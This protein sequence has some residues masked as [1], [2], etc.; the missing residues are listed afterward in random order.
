MLNT[1]SK[2]SLLVFTA[3]SA[4]LGAGTA[5]CAKEDPLFCT[6]DQMCD[7]GY[8]YCDVSGA[9][10]ASGFHGNTCIPEPC[11]DAGPPDYDAGIADAGVDAGSAPDAYE[12]QPAALD[13]SP[14]GR[15]FGSVVLGNQSGSATFVVTNV[16]E[17][18]SGSISVT[19][20]GAAAGDF[21][22]ETDD[23]TGT[24]SPSGTCDIDVHFAPTATSARLATLD[25]EASPGGM[26]SA[27]LDGIGLAAGDLSLSP[28]THGFGTVSV[29][30]TT[31]AV[32]L[33]VT[34][35]GGSPTGTLVTTL[36]DE[37]NFGITT[38]NC[39]DI[40]LNAGASCT[41]SVAASPTSVGAQVGSLTVEATPG[42]QTA[43][44]LTATGEVQ[45]DIVINGL[46]GGT[47]TSVPAGID[48]GSDC[49]QSY[50]SATSVTLTATPASNAVFVGWSGGGCNGSG[51]CNIATDAHRTVTATF[52][53]NIIAPLLLSPTNGAMTGSHF[54]AASLQPSLQWDASA[55]ADYY[56]LEIDDSCTVAGFASCTFASPEVQ[57]SNIMGTSFQAPTLA[58]STSA[59]VGRRY[60]WRVRACDTLGCSGWSPVRY[61]DVGRQR[62]DYNADG[63]ADLLIGAFGQ[64]V[65]MNEKEGV[66]FLY[67]GQSQLGSTIDS[68]DT[69]IANPLAQA[70]SFMGVHVGPVGDANGDGYPDFAVTTPRA[71]NPESEEGVAHLYY[72]RQSFP[73]DLSSADVTFDCPVDEANAHF[74]EVGM[75]GGD[76]NGDGYSDLVVTAPNANSTATDAGHA[77]V[78]FGGTSIATTVS[79]ADVTIYPPG[80]PTTPAYFGDPIVNDVDGDGLLDIIVGVPYLENPADDEGAIAI[81]LGRDSWPSTI[82]VPDT[83][84]S[85]PAAVINQTLGLDVTTC[86]INGDGFGDVIAGEVG[87]NAN[88]GRVF[89]YFGARTWAATIT[90]GDVTISNPI[91]D[92]TWFGRNIACGRSVTNDAIDDLVVGAVFQDN[93]ED[94]EGGAYLFA[95]RETF[96]PTMT[97]PTVRFDNPAD[98]AY[99]GFGADVSIG[100]DVDGDGFGDVHIGASDAAIAGIIQ[101]ETFLYLGRASWML[102]TTSADTN[103]TN[104]DG[105]NGQFGDSVH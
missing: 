42:G 44:S 93:P 19:L 55:G 60:Y 25:V 4:L 89:I 18:T 8:A 96:S 65:G 70:N 41:V 23:C 91:A 22:I 99:G 40:S 5:G 53:T 11:W 71:S 38:D 97:S 87:Y 24:L 30:A 68:E 105:Q 57:Q 79:T 59:P 3:I 98:I 78:Y 84:I 48:C 82:S 43:T 52:N 26:T 85:D 101:A 34:N 37:T 36:D 2:R 6:A 33:T 69:R 90:Q 102:D 58:V 45:L 81:Y 54:A 47:V 100:G 92:A 10:P 86:D 95:G 20:G 17:S 1:S 56:E 35:D 29:G 104:P 74:G 83:L 76:L 13:I 62:T 28:T 72:G 61:V 103:F 12:A 64:D 73:A 9:C 31:G 94:R 46:N 16:G 80:N 50:T 77:Y 51:T 14:G 88:E 75:D 49:S 15:S 63:Y 32:V 27:D 21:I 66:V 39:E 67:F 7:E